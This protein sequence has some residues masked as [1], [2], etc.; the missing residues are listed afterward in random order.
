MRKNRLGNTFQKHN[1]ED[2]IFQKSE[3]HSQRGTPSAA[4]WM[5]ID[6]GKGTCSSH[7]ST[8]HSCRQSTSGEL[9]KVTWQV[10]VLHTCIPSTLETEAR[11]WQV[12]DQLRSHIH[13]HLKKQIKTQAK[14]KKIQVFSIDSEDTGD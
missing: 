11:E 7:C 5:G 1:Y 12:R 6:T 10:C 8:G 9:H 13:S 2:I 14:R 3:G 4:Q